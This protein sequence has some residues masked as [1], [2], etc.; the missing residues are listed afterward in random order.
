M[1]HAVG[2]RTRRAIALAGAMAVAVLSPGVA[3]AETASSSYV[4]GPDSANWYWKDQVEQT[5]AAG[6]VA[7]VVRLPNPQA[8]DTLLVAAQDGQPNK[9]SAVSFDL[10]R[11][12]VEAGSSISKFTFRIIESDELVPT[13]QD[14]SQPDTQPSFNTEGK[15]IQACPITGVW[16]AG[17]GAELW[18]LAPTYD[19]AG[20]VQGKRAESAGVIAWMF[21]VT[22]LAQ[23]WAATPSTNPGMMLVPVIPEGAA[24]TDSTWQVNLKLPRRDDDNTESADEYEQTK[25]RVQVSLA[26]SP[27]SDTSSGGNFTG[28]GTNFDPTTGTG[29]PGSGFPFDSP[30]VTGGTGGSPAGGEQTRT[31]A[32]TSSRTVP[33]LPWY[34]WVLIPVGLMAVSTVRAVVLEP[35]AT[36]K[37][38]G[39][40]V[41]IRT[42]NAELRGMG[43]RGPAA[44]RRGMSRFARAMSFGTL[45]RRGWESIT[46]LATRTR[47]AVRRR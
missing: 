4:Y 13:S 24:S 19:T 14:A 47:R 23:E 1:A 27:P 44:A 7:Q 8:P 38:G 32:P 25:D 11:R 34:V 35:L 2:R 18:E 6:P 22:T 37:P 43:S 16:S 33:Q 45:G 28:G 36:G 20:C 17:E 3:H 40:I 31:S 5:V 10:S 12:G 46:A 30:P 41:A 21:D 39:V 9:I 15:F 26:F 29:S 42:K